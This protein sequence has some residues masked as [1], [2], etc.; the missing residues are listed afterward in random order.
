MKPG[1]FK[2]IRDI[3]V[4]AFGEVWLV[5]DME[6]N[7]TCALKVL[8]REAGLSNHESVFSAKIKHPNVLHI[9]DVFNEPY[10]RCVKM[11]YVDG[12]TLEQYIEKTGPQLWKAV[13]PLLTK[14][15]HGVQALGDDGFVHRDL[16]SSNVLLTSGL[17]PKIADFGQ[18]CR[19]GTDINPNE[20]VGT[21]PYAPPERSSPGKWDVRADVRKDGGSVADAGG[22]VRLAGKRGEDTAAVPG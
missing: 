21:L 8:N 17:E 2:K 4:G 7:E 22:A 6:T 20:A 12:G 3:G 11:E 15:A 1:R 18:L 10:G 13:L 14:I 9:Y 16:K 5:T 19:I